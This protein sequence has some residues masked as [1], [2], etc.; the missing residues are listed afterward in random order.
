VLCARYHYL[1]DIYDPKEV[2]IR[3]TD[4]ARTQ[5]SVQ[6]MFA[7][8]LYPHDKRPDGAPIQIRTR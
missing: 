2:Y 8:G 4:Y 6:Q 3:S 7:G 5:E 1:S